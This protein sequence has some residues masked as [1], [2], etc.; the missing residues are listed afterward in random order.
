MDEEV[1]GVFDVGLFYIK[2]KIRYNFLMFV[3]LFFLLFEDLV[4]D[5]EEDVEKI[6][7]FVKV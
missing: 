1:V 2:K 5:C 7:E 3:K 6:K 4:F